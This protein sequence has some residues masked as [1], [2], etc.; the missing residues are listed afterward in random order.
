MRE[1]TIDEMKSIQV[2]ILTNVHDFCEKNGIKYSLYAGTL[3][4]AIRHKGFIPWDDDIDIVMT[5]PNYEKF[6]H[7]YKD[8]DGIYKLHELSTDPDYALQYA[9]VED[10]R[11]ILKENTSLKTM[12][13]NIDIFPC[14]N[15]SDTKEDSIAIFQKCAKIKFMHFGKLV[16]P[17]KKN[18]FFKKICIL[19]L[20][21]LLMFYSMRNLAKKLDKMAK[22]MGKANSK[23]VGPLASFYGG[24]SIRGNSCAIWPR[25]IFDDYN[26]VPFEDRQF[27]VMK[28]YDTY[29][30]SIYG[31]YMQ[32]PPEGE[33]QSPHT[34]NGV[35]WK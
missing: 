8:D 5:R 1:I 29:L 32:L 21:I 22:T 11:T 6:I 20:K 3:I 14:D 23:Y 28:G 33:R 15:L 30:T 10:T 9:K 12:G 16:K 35:Y 7:G 24:R 18:S 26:L 27:Y 31:D 34:L 2:D 13:I 25:E 19:G 17:G 4:G